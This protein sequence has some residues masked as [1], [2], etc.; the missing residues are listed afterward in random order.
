MVLAL[1]ANM[2][3]ST[4]VFVVIVAMIVRAIRTQPGRVVTAPSPEVVRAARCARDVRAR[5][6]RGIVSPAR[7][8][9]GA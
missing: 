8:L 2:A 5:Q 7:Q 9:P 4:I 1:I 3:L 6:A